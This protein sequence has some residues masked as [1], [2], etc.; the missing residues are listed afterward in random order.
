MTDTEGK[1]GPAASDRETFLRMSRQRQKDTRPEILTRRIL[2]R[3]GHRF[4]IANRDLPGS[5]DI[6]N[7]HR[8][9][10]VFVHGCYWHRHEGCPRATTPKRNREFWME[11][12]EANQARDR[13]VAD[14]LRNRGFTVLTVWECETRDLEALEERLGRELPPDHSSGA[15]SKGGS[16]RRS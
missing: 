9:W 15:H 8:R 14:K 4:R 5:P 10:A 7:R 2:H 11:K 6:A 3:L 13:R 12:F 1:R 16:L